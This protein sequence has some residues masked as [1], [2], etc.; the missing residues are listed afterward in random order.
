MPM[1]D[2]PTNHKPVLVVGGTGAVGRHLV[3]L[4][5]SEGRNVIAVIA[6]LGA[7]N[8]PLVV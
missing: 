5:T 6:G 8:G 3:T 1:A 4:L 2:S 7:L